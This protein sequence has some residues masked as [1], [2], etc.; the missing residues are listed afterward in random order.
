MNIY[1]THAING[2]SK[3][4]KN[5]EIIESYLYKNNNSKMTLHIFNKYYLSQMKI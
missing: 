4:E 1:R 3:Q 2:L 5:D